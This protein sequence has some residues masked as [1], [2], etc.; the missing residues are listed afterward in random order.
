[1]NSASLD[2]SAVPLS[3]GL[4]DSPESLGLC[5]IRRNQSSVKA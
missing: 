1:M 3:A 4:L 5:R 2:L